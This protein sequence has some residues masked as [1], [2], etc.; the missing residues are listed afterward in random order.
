[1]VDATKVIA[2]F[3]E[4][5]AQRL[6]GLS[7]RQLG[8]W[9]R[10]SFFKPEFRAENPHTPFSRI[11]SFMDVVSLRVLSVLRN[12]F[13]V[14]LQH[15]RQVSEKLSHLDKERWTKTSLYVLNKK[16][17]F[18]DP[19]TG[20]PREIVSG[21]YALPI[22][23][24]EVVSRTQTDVDALNRR[25]GD[26][27]G[28]ITRNRRISHNASVIAGTRI[29]TVAIKRFH[30]AGYTTAQIMKEYPDLT[31]QDVEAALAHKEKHAAV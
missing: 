7:T 30:V 24:S 10:T 25:A 21:Q 15:L 6:T 18:S 23:L 16:V 22:V 28:A 13:G 1:M 27:I 14:S 9:D 26:Q 5:Q 4:E 20:L 17:L 11:Y 2:A 12:Q 29:P 31:E 19:E 8:H 3:T